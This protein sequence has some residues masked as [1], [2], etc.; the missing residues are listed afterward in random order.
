MNDQVTLAERRVALNKIRDE[1]ADKWMPTL[2]TEQ[3]VE[4]YA[5]VKRRFLLVEGEYEDHEVW[6]TTHETLAQATD[7][8]ASTFIDPD[9]RWEP[10][11]IV[12]LDTGE[13][14]G[15][16]VRVELTEYDPIKF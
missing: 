11:Y 4:Y 5:N 8:A 3:D 2:M 7:G 1:Y 12:D 10:L 16:E 13:R 14:W 9:N 15:V 6:Y